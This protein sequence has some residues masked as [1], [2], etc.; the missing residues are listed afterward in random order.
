MVLDR[1]VVVLRVCWFCVVPRRWRLRCW[2]LVV[3]VYVMMWCREVCR[4][5]WVFRGA[6]LCW[7]VVGM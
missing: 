4:V 6:R 7:G 2:E 1:V 3:V 5:G